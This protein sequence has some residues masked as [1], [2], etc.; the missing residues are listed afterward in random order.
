MFV[1]DVALQP[2]AG[3][4]VTPD[5]RGNLGD[6]L[7][8]GHVFVLVEI[9]GALGEYC[10]WLETRAFRGLVG[11]LIERLSSTALSMSSFELGVMIKSVASDSSLVN[12][13]FELFLERKIFGRCFELG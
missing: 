5:Q 12:N 3:L 6:M 2:F 1:R 8:A 10:M 11:I 7:I 13:Q 4:G 9:L